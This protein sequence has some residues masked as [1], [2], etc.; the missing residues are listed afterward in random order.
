MQDAF[1]ERPG[2]LFG[3]GRHVIRTHRRSPNVVFRKQGFGTQ[4]LRFG[5]TLGGFWEALGSILPPWGASWLLFPHFSAMFGLQ[6]CSC[7]YVGFC[8]ILGA[9]G[10]VRGGATHC[11]GS[12]VTL[13]RLVTFG[14]KTEVSLESGA[15]S[16]FQ[17][18]LFR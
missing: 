15:F 7:S 14:M 8:W 5:V 16:G 1:L 11:E 9:G 6:G 2:E 17:G 13:L 10:G 3:R 4:R 12:L 18:Y